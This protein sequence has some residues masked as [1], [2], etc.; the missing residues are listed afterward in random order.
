MEKIEMIWKKYKW[1]ILIPVMIIG[2]VIYMCTGAFGSEE[3]TVEKAEE[4]SASVASSGEEE[5]P[6]LPAENIYVDV[7]GAVASPGVVILPEGSRIFEA[8]DAAGGVLAEGVTRYLNLAALCE[9]GGKIYVPDETEAEIQQQV[10]GEPYLPDTAYSGQSSG[11]SYSG[12][13]TGKIN[14]NLA[15]SA[16]LQTLSGIGPS[17]AQRIIDYRTRNGKYADVNDLTNVSG[18]GEKTLNKI[19]DKICV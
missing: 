13:E 15:D 19:I 7:G 6:A 12:T 9:D 5:A 2:T 17:M 18:I 1:L 14:I 4:S 11:T 8:L 16:A 10:S 3:I